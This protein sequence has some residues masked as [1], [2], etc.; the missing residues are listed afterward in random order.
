MKS[1]FTYTPIL[2]HPDLSRE[3]LVEVDAS[4]SGVGV[5]LSQ[6]YR[7]DQKLHPCAFISWRHW[8]EGLAQPFM[9][10]TDHKNL[11]YLR[12]S[13]RLSSWLAQWALFLGRFRLSAGS[14]RLVTLMVKQSCLPLLSNTYRKRDF[15]HSPWSL[16]VFCCYT[17]PA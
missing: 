9:I 12:N 15:F 8:L 14:I 17:P 7:A 5:V 10:W 2:S 13:K 4:D 1:L 6:S 11:S 3:F 16:T